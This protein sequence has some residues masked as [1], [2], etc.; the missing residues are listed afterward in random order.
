MWDGNGAADLA[1]A[2]SKDGVRAAAGVIHARAARAA[3]GVAQCHQVLH[4]VVVGNQA[5]R[6][7]C[8]E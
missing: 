5:F 4:V 3:M 7:I 2:N 8:T 1:E 6:Q